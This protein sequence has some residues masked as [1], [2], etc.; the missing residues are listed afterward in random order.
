MMINN[1]FKNLKIIFMINSKTF[2]NKMLTKFRIETYTYNN[3]KT[4][5]IYFSY[6]TFEV[7]D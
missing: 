2:S 7:N 6:K 4:S 1:L 3:S 5:Y